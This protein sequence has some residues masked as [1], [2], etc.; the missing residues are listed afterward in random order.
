MAFFFVGQIRGKRGNKTTDGIWKYYQRIR[1]EARMRNEEKELAYTSLKT[2]FARIHRSTK[3]QIDTIEAGAVDF[4]KDL[5]R[6]LTKL[7]EWQ[8]PHAVSQFVTKLALVTDIDNLLDLCVSEI[9][10]LLGTKYCSILTVIHGTKKASPRLVLR[11]TNFSW[12]KGLEGTKAYRK[13]QGLTGWVWKN[14]CSLRLDNIKDKAEL[15]K[16]PGLKWTNTI[17]DS[18]HHREWLGVPLYGWQGDV[19]GVIRVPEKERTSKPSGGGFTFEDEVLLLKIGQY[20]AR[21][22]EELSAG[23]RIRTALRASQECAVRLCLAANRTLIAETLV[24]TCKRIFGSTGKLHAFIMLAE[25]NRTFRVEVSTGSLG[26]KHLDKTTFPVDESLGGMAL[27]RGRAVIV[28]DLK[29]AQRKKRYYPAVPALACA[30]T[31]PICFGEK[32]Y[33]ILS[34]GADRKYAFSEEPDLHI[35]GDLSSI[36]GATLA[37][38]DAEKES[39]AAFAEFS[40]RMG[41]TLNSRIA[42]LEGTI[43]GIDRKKS[44]RFLKETTK[45]IQVVEFLKATANLGIQFGESWDQTKF[46]KFDLAAKIKSIKALWEDSRIRLLV[47]EPLKMVGDPELL[48]HMLLEL[49]GNALRFVP[50]RKGVV[51]I[52][53]YRRRS[54]GG[55]L[56]KRFMVIEV[57][58]NGPG[59]PEDDKESIFNPYR[60][61]DESR[62]GLGLSIVKSIAE[63]HKG[64][65]EERG[66]PGHGACFRIVLPQ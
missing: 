26:G 10:M 66:T 9:P 11:K 55:M 2:K 16:Y 31:A 37:R 60:T 32:K 47:K 5:S 63:A 38:L 28:H 30:M 39:K 22:I 46:S 18:E 53:G 49:V 41:H 59:V 6:I 3:E 56:Q 33:G 12:S 58:D 27:H 62:P 36:A 57:E 19:I 4:A 13:G 44:S 35:L 43:A 20:V 34:V 1:G 14:A 17:C 45:I 61:S 42:M 52:H 29:R 48:E 21:Q 40:G 8:R 51:T 54:R 15:E 24:A 65:V 25:D 23:E 50:K 7:Q 64:H